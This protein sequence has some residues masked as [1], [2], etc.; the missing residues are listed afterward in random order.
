MSKKKIW[1]PSALTFAGAGS[2]FVS[3]ICLLEGRYVAGMLWMFL[4]VFFDGID[5]KV[6]SL[7]GARSELG[8]VLDSQ[9]DVVS[10]AL[11]PGVALFLFFQRSPQDGLL[12]EIAAWT[13]GIGYMCAGIFREVRFLAT[14]M[15]R[16][17]SEGFIGLPIAPPAGLNVAMLSLANLFP[18]LFYRPGWHVAVFVVAA[19]NAYLMTLGTINY[20]RWGGHAIVLQTLTALIA[21]VAAYV[22][23]GT[24]G[25]FLAAFCFSFCAIYISFHPIQSLIQRIAVARPRQA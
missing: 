4:A 18:H 11:L 10:F 13:A 14:Q 25:A 12:L 9:C 1:I 3:L 5:G 23:L 19:L 24:G 16:E 20:H 7:L 22:L 17:R 6:A 2:G 21:G 8:A 15:D